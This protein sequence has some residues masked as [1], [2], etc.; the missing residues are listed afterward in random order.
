MLRSSLLSWHC[1]SGWID[2]YPSSWREYILSLGS[3]DWVRLVDLTRRSTRKRLAPSEDDTAIRAGAIAVWTSVSSVS[4]SPELSAILALDRFVPGDPNYRQFLSGLL[5]RPQNHH[6]R[7]RSP[8]LIHWD[9]PRAWLEHNRRMLQL[10]VVDEYRNVPLVHV[11][12]NAYMLHQMPHA[13]PQCLI[14]SVFAHHLKKF[15]DDQ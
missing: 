7:D 1:A 9:D 8:E 4:P 5:E 6:D 14:S 11:V 12:G 2:R 15:G 10:S 13:L 3:R